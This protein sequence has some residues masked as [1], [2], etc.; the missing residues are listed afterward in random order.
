MKTET[1]DAVTRAIGQVKTGDD[2]RAL[3]NAFW[4]VT[5][6]EDMTDKET[7][8]A[9]AVLAGVATVALLDYAVMLDDE[10]VIIE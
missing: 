4:I 9:L 8:T 5:H 6:D 1:S 10:R 2:A 3:A 7:V